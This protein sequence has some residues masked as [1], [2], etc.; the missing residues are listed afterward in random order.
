[1][2]S[3]GSFIFCGYWFVALSLSG[4][5][6][7]IGSLYDSRGFINAS[8]RKLHGG[9]LARRRETAYL[10]TNLTVTEV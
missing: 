7:A 6:G 1:M 2:K 4:A 5:I 9:R 3:L 8:P 10:Q